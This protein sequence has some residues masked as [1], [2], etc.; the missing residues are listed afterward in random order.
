MFERKAVSLRDGL[1]FG[2][3][4][5]HGLRR[6]TSTLRCPIS[7]LRLRSARRISTAPVKMAF[8]KIKSR[9]FSFFLQ[10]AQKMP[11]NAKLK[12]LHSGL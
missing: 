12:H 3:S 5:R 7:A 1:K 6:V 2:Y 10:Q 11:L 4:F 9:P 8:T